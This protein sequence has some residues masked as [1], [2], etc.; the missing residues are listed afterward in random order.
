MKPNDTKNKASDNPKK[1]NDIKA[2][3]NQLPNIH[4]LRLENNPSIGWAHPKF[5]HAHPLAWGNK[6]CILEDMVGK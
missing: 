5:T 6:N 1:L 4:I 3:L 2:W